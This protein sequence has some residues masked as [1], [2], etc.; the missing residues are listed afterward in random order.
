SVLCFVCLV[1]LTFFGALSLTPNEAAAQRQART[2]S[3]DP[4]R[5]DPPVAAPLDRSD[6]RAQLSQELSAAQPLPFPTYAVPG[7]AEN[8]PLGA[9]E[10]AFDNTTGQEE[11][12]DAPLS[13]DKQDV[14]SKVPQVFPAN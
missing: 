11:L 5:Q 6:P 7:A 14:L 1:A 10:A 2:R 4:T 3:I 9:A 13:K 8:N 12:A